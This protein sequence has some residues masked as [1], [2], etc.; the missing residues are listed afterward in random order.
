MHLASTRAPCVHPKPDRKGS[1]P[2]RYASTAFDAMGCRFEILIDSLRAPYERSECQAICEEMREVVH[3]WHDRLSVFEKGSVVSRI[4]NAAGGEPIALDD[5]MFQLLEIC[6]QLRIQTRGAFNIASGT[7]MERFGFRG[8]Q[9][10]FADPTSD[11]P[12]VFDHRTDLGSAVKLDRTLKTLTKSHTEISIDFGA[13]AKGYVIDLLRNELVTYRIPHAFIHGGTS[14]VLAMGTNHDDE[15]WT[16]EV[17]HEND[18]KS[19]RCVVDLSGYCAGISEHHAR[20]LRYQDQILGHVMDPRTNEPAKNDLDQV[21]CIHK[22][23]AVADAVSTALCV[24]P[25]LYSIIQNENCFESECTCIA[26]NTINTEPAIT[27]HDPL[28]IVRFVTRTEHE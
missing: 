26:I 21:V 18:P 5:D 25:K 11:M 23:A 4:N 12:E 20:S 1:V 28:R 19:S 13:I 10:S 27:L 8:D 9:R 24:N 7:L 3:E 22:S 6:D 2:E 17:A 14:S 16:I 15:P